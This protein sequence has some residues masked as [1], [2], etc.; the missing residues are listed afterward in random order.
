MKFVQ[1]E[2]LTPPPGVIS[3]LKSGFDITANHISI[4]LLPILLDIFL[5]FGPH[6]R[7][8]NLMRDWVVQFNLLSSESIVPASEAQRFEQ[9]QDLLNEALTLD[10]NL[11][12]FL[13]TFPIGI[14]SLM[15]GFIPGQTPLGTPPSFQAESVFMIFLWFGGLTLVG[16]LLGSI[17]FTWVAKVSI[18]DEDQNLLWA[19]KTVLH[20]MLLSLIWSAALFMMGMPLAIMFM[21]FAQIN[22]ILA[23]AALIFLALF[24]M[25]II[26]PFFFSAH[27]IFT[28]RENV[29]RSIISS[30]HLSRFTLPTSSFF[31]LGVLLLSQGFNS[32]WLVPS[33][34]SWMLLISIFGHAFI[35][36]SLLAAS[37][38]YYR[39][40]NIWLETLLKKIDS[41]V[42]SAQF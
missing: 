38:I 41:K 6:L 27:G 33:D 22:P 15:K 29:I 12:S 4:I 2:T 5:W 36:T 24:A 37:F 10:I 26:V 9:F 34:S 35:T 31:V 3:S 16:W 1:D 19:G 40:M 23:Q 17:Y 18:Q 7:I 8:D 39:D 11:F 14:S 20:A 42:T 13:R 28:K 25:W 32:L 21:V 30:F